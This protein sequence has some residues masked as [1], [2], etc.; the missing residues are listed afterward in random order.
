MH[1]PLTIEYAAQHSTGSTIPY[2]TWGGSL[3]KMPVLIPPPAVRAAFDGVVRPLLDRISGM[4]F[5]NS[6]LA[7]VRD[8]LLPK[9]ISGKLTTGRAHAAAVAVPG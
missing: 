5:E 7:E 3:E 6:T 1:D 8:S 9:L 4:Y 2:A